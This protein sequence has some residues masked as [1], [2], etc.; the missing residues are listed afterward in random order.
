MFKSFILGM[1]FVLVFAVS[2]SAQTA[3]LNQAKYV[4]TLKVIA[5]HK[6]NDADLAPDIDR[7]RENERFNSTL[8]KM[9][10]KLDNSRPNTAKNQKIMRILEKAGKEIYDELK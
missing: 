7:L 9:L 5:D 1:F 2:A 10:A 3:S 6:M 4:T 8:K